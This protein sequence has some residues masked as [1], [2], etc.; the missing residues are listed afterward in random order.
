MLLE[1]Y[2]KK[3]FADVELKLEDENSE[4]ERFWCYL[5]EESDSPELIVWIEGNVRRITTIDGDELFS[6]DE[7]GCKSFVK[8]YMTDN[9]IEETKEEP[10]HV[11]K[12]IDQTVEV[13]ESVTVLEEPTPEFDGIDLNDFDSDNSFSIKTDFANILVS[14][15]NYGKVNIGYKIHGFWS[16]S[17]LDMTFDA[18]Y[19]WEEKSDAEWKA[20]ISRSSGGEE[21]DFDH[22]LGQLNYARSLEHAV[23]FAKW[24][25]ENAIHFSTIRDE[26][27]ERVQKLRKEEKRKRE[28]E[29]G[30]ARV[31][32]EESYRLATKAESKKLIDSMVASY[33]ESF[34]EQEQTVLLRDNDYDVSEH[35]IEYKRNGS[36]NA[37]YLDGV[38]TG[39]SKII[40]RL[41]E[42]WSVVKKNSNI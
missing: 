11:A 19:D 32:W 42:S 36:V 20:E 37:F 28:E 33:K 5:N 38:K 8:Q 13:E 31:E 7:K 41:V 25:E 27:R 17:S 3:H 21:G 2:L 1:T 10:T 29:L 30:V 40:D 34:K 15:S 22:L 4:M 23:S 6:G 26:E 14:V 18:K 35:K 39:A 16:S 24:L 9:E 12:E